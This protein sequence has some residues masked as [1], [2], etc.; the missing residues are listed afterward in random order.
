MWTNGFSVTLPSSA[1][2]SDSDGKT[3]IAPLPGG[4]AQKPESNPGLKHKAARGGAIALASQLTQFVVMLGATMVL[5]RLLNQEDF[6]L[7]GMVLP[8]TGLLRTLRD[9]GLNTATIQRKELSDDLLSSIFWINLAI[10]I[11]ITLSLVPL[12]SV[13]VR[14]YEQPALYWIT[15]AFAATFTI[16]ALASQH[17]AL[18]RRH[19]RFHAQAT[20]ELSA[21]VGS[22]G[23]GIAM[24]LLGFGYWAIVGSQIA[25]SVIS[26]TA[27]WIVEPWRPALP[28]RATG[29]RAMLR[30]GGYVTA[31]NVMNYLFRNV[32]NVLIGWRWGP[33]S[34]G[35]YQK[36]Y[37]LVMLPIQHITS[38]V[39]EVAV[40]TLSRLQAD[41]VRMRRYFIAGYAIVASATIPASV[42]TVLFAEDLVHLFLG[43]KWMDAVPLFRWLAPGALL[44]ALLSPLDWLFTACG[45]VDRQLKAGAAWCILMLAG[46]A[47][48]L[49]YGPQGVALGFSAVS[50]LAAL[51]LCYYALRETPVSASDM[52]SALVLPLLAA[53]F[54]GGITMLVKHYLLGEIPFGIRAIISCTLLVVFY[55]LILLFG[56]RQWKHCLEIVRYIISFRK[57][58][59]A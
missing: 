11:I 42:G 30:F 58:A 47:V 15:L 34:L 54:A 21:A 56:L 4:A 33:A 19:M 18:I 31:D 16:D 25:M 14:L 38:P 35:V 50:I 28:R 12:A 36:A 52:G 22:A 27:A 40:S 3:L 32:D 2:G 48:G 51:P 13:V 41:P 23:T 24:A 39:H 26:M 45:H 53:T 57:S 17:Q 1:A 8:M 7:V 49:P 10:G 55:A 46:F 44:I 5:A 59:A 29:A 6:G 20:I 9:A 37:S 43:A